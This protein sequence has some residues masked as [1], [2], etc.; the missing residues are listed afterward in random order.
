[1]KDKYEK[2]VLGVAVL[3][4][5]AMIA[6]GGMKL[7]AVE[8][9][10]W[11]ADET[12]TEAPPIAGAEK[13][14]KN[15]NLLST[16]VVLGGVKTDKGR[17][18][19]SFTGVPL[20]VRRGSPGSK[21]VD[22]TG[23]DEEPVHLDIPNSWWFENGL[24]DEIGY[25]DAPQRDFDHDGFSNLEEFKEQSNP[26]DKNSCPSLFAKIKVANIEKSNWT[27]RFTPYGPGRLNFKMR[28][29]FKGKAAEARMKGGK[30]VQ[31]GESFF[32]EGPQQNRFKLAQ[33]VKKEAN[34]IQREFAMVEDLKPGKGNKIYEIAPGR[35]KVEF[36][37]YT[38]RLYL[39]TP[40]HRDQ[41]IE[42]EEGMS[43]SLPYDEKATAKP[44][45]LK[46]IGPDGQTALLLWEHAGE[47]KEQELRAEN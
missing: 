46:S 3:I 9:D 45:T 30:T 14:A 19:D 5:V 44:Y 18:V 33:I 28:Y 27:L 39:D 8:N 1:M 29:S 43:F 31:V 12:Q 23:P 21:G 13:I 10:F 36:T 25:G 11:P 16:P 22:I 7:K 17:S 15:A 34:G 37:D 4:A 6:L 38:A 35:P 41:K 20:Y 32:A 40:D 24:D 47:T 26:N 42:V 2:V